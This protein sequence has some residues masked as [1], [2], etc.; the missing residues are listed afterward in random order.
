M[1]RDKIADV[2]GVTL[3]IAFRLLGKGNHMNGVRL[4]AFCSSRLIVS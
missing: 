3:D 4:S 2:T 1:R